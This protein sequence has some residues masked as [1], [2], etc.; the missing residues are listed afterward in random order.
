MFV[1]VRSG[2][3]KSAVVL[4]LP[5]TGNVDR[6][7]PADYMGVN[8]TPTPPADHT[9]AT[10]ADDPRVAIEAALGGDGL[11]IV[12]QPI[13]ELESR[14][15]VGFEALARFSA[16]PLRSPDRW[17]A[18]AAALGL[19]VDLEL[20]ALDR[21]FE[22][23]P[24]VP[25][26]TYLSVNASPAT[27][28]SAGFGARLETIERL[29]RI[30]LEVTEHAPISDYDQFERA[31]E[32]HRGRGLALAIDDT[33]A[34]FASLRHI[35]RLRPDT[36]KLDR[37]ITD[38][39]DRDHNTRALAAALTSFA[40]E[41]QATV[42][43]EGIEASSQLSMMQALGVSLGQGYLLGRPAL[44]ERVSAPPS[45]PSTRARSTA[46]CP[47]PAPASSSSASARPRSASTG[48]SPRSAGWS[49]MRN[50]TPSK[51]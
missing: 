20:A 9:L 22:L 16:L 10:P 40:L 21:A 19:G 37:S 34:G 23:L 18:A 35:L 26:G 47:S 29:D 48:C 6:P 14:A 38:V 17:F 2:F 46:S 4:T 42:T 28:L 30:V 49:S 43:A 12:C 15:V 33:G 44:L 24:I 27:V 45:E 25:A 32:Q 8:V 31:L 5:Q 7:V 3:L 1:G 36:I 50:T 11:T 41:T 51:R 13:V 39:I